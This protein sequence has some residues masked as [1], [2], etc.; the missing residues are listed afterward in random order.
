MKEPK[1]K[2]RKLKLAE[3]VGA[4]RGVLTVTAFERYGKRRT[5]FARVIC[6]C[7][8]EELMPW[9]YMNKK[10][11]VSCGFTCPLRPPRKEETNRSRSEKMKAYR[12]TLKGKNE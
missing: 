7:G 3:L 5:L 8:K 4:K 1:T 2:R 6:D 11:P 10:V 12:A 9:Q